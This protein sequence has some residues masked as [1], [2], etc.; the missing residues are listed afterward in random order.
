[1]FQVRTTAESF[2]AR[3]SRVD[4][5]CLKWTGGTTKAGYGKATLNYKTISA[6]RLAWIFTNGKIRRGLQVLHRCDNPL[7]IEPTHLFLGTA[8]ENQADKIRKGRHRQGPNAPG[9]FRR[10]R[11]GRWVDSRIVGGV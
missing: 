1:M 9:V 7:C 10:D 4:G 11:G 3:G 6:H 2:F 5:G 8:K